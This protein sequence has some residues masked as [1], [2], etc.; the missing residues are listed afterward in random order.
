[1]LLSYII[2]VKCEDL[3]HQL[4]LDIRLNGYS[5]PALEGTSV[6]LECTSPNLVHMGPNITTCMGN[7][8]WEPDPRDVKCV[9][10]SYEVRVTSLNNNYVFI[11]HIQLTV[12]CLWLTV[13]SI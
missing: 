6:T 9:G 2:I 3:L 7:G 12:E 10:E 11:Y 5:D 13:V 4:G 1:M 8:E